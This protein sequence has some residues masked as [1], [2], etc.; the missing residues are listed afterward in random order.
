MALV[1]PD[2]QSIT[3]GTNGYDSQAVEDATDLAILAA[4]GDETG[5]I[6]GCGV[7]AQGSPNMTVQVAAGTVIIN[8]LVV[9]VAAVASQTIAAADS[10]DR[11]DIVVVNNSGTVSVTKGTD[12]GTAGWTRTSTNLPPVKPSIPANSVVLAEV[13]VTSTTTS[14]AAANIVDKTNIIS[15]PVT[16]TVLTATT[17]VTATATAAVT[18]LN[19]PLV[20]SQNYDFE[21][22]LFVNNSSSGSTGVS[23]GVV[24]P[25]G[26]TLQYSV[27][28][29]TNSTT[30]KIVPFSSSTAQTGGFI[31]TS[32]FTGFIQ[33]AGSVQ[34]GTATGSIQVGVSSQTSTTSS[35]HG[36]ATVNI[37]SS[38]V[39]TPV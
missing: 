25:T 39:M 34:M 23:I 13:V 16:G 26:A 29:C 24:V 33:I 3:N 6:S 5:V 14:V 17:T 27:L 10:T 20:P 31:T 7:T 12:C 1:I 32:G 4:A 35:N 15:V 37:G 36:T 18:A 9:P 19:Q 28:G 30:T 21:C 11:R 38:L 22:N 8:G 2:I